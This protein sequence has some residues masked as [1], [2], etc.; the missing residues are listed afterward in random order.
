MM[1]LLYYV[2]NLAMILC[3]IYPSYLYRLHTATVPCGPGTYLK[4]ED[5]QCHFCPKSH[6]QDVEGQAECKPCP[7]GQYTSGEGAFSVHHCLGDADNDV[8]TTLKGK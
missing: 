7:A 1:F 6:Y 8:N 5:N 2:D 3:V 4:A